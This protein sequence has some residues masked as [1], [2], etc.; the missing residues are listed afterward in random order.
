MIDKDSVIKAQEVEILRLQSALDDLKNWA[1]SNFRFESLSQGLGDE[2]VD[3]AELIYQ[4]EKI[5]GASNA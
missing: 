2:I 3:L 1:I 5:T 4:I